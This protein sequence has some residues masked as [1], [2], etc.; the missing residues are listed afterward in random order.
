MTANQIYKM[1]LD[2]DELEEIG[3]TAAATLKRAL[4]Y[5]K[6]KKVLVSDVIYH[7]GNIVGTV[8]LYKRRNAY[9]GDGYDV[10]TVDSPDLKALVMDTFYSALEA[11]TEYKKINVDTS[12]DADGP[13]VKLQIWIN[14]HHWKGH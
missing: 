4:R 2:A 13:C 3:D 6:G 1:P 12:V 9:F 14:E 8:Y 7:G 10:T 5:V 11:A